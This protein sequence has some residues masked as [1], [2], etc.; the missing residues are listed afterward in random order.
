[1]AVQSEHIEVKEKESW[2]VLLVSLNAV[3]FREFEAS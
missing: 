3:L 2:N 1:M